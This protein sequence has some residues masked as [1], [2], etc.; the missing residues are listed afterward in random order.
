MSQTIDLS[1]HNEQNLVIWGSGALKLPSGT[2]SQRPKTSRA[3]AGSIRWNTTLKVFEAFDGD[4]W[5]T[6]TVDPD[7]EFLDM[8]VGGYLDGSL[9][10][11]NGSTITGLPTP[12]DPSDAAS[13]DYVENFAN[14]T[15]LPLE[16]PTVSS[17][18]LTMSGGKI[19]SVADPEDPE[20][21]VNLRTLEN[22]LSN[23]PTPSGGFST[24][25]AFWGPDYFDVITDIPSTASFIKVRMWGSGGAGSRGS[26]SGGRGGSAGA[27]V[28][29]IA[30][31]GSNK[32]IMIDIGLPGAPLGNGSGGNGGDTVVT[33]GGTA[34]IAGG[35]GGASATHTAGAGGA[36]SGIPSSSFIVP[37]A[38][39]APALTLGTNIG[40][41]GIGGASHGFS[42]PAP[43]ADIGTSSPYPGSGGNGGAPTPSGTNDG[44]S[45]GVGLVII[46]Y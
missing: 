4:K 19:V 11:R 37:G 10:L 6:V 23:L 44:G 43:S 31:L 33:I 38:Q 17:G 9:E 15:F 41:G 12:T 20:D 32:N 22:A 45:G 3:W 27:Y 26:T 14:S 18:N 24:L 13:K 39:G 46:E 7:A 29:F 35:G 2:S 1:S 16:N 34:Y 21:V 40:I 5:I 42:S 36:A 28:E 30:P 8:K 25:R